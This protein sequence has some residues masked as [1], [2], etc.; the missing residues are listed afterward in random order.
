MLRLLYW[1]YCNFLG[2]SGEGKLSHSMNK[3]VSFLKAQRMVDKVCLAHLTFIWDTSAEVVVVREF[4]NVFSIDFSGIPPDRND[5]FG[6]DLV[7]DA[8]LIS[9]SPYYI[10]PANLKESKEKLQYLLSKKLLDQVFF[11]G[12]HWYVLLRKMMVL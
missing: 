5:E 9:I 11:L 6:I 7:L 12:V 2:W 1:L 4:T 10:A 3:V 8:Q